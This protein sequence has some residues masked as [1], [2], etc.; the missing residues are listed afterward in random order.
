MSTVRRR[1]RWKV[2]KVHTCV[3]KRDKKKRGGESFSVQKGQTECD[4]LLV[5]RVDI[6]AAR[7]EVDDTAV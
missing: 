5:R 6:P 1:W 2:S 4:Q 7:R 3:G